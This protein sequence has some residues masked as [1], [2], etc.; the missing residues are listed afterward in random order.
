MAISYRWQ[1]KSVAVFWR[2]VWLILFGIENTWNRKYVSFKLSAILQPEFWLNINKIAKHNSRRIEDKHIHLL[3]EWWSTI[4]THGTHLPSI[5]APCNRCKINTLRSR[6]NGRHFADD[7][8]K[9]IFEN[10]NVAFRLKKIHGSLFLRV[11]WTIFQ[12]TPDH[13]SL[14][15]IVLP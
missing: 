10:G 6:Q 15:E 1:V 5:K 9:C 3:P 11:Q 8:F 13:L 14:V 4:N 2:R 7:I 12:Q